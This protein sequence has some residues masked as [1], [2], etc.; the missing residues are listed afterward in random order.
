MEHKK[1]NS[2]SSFLKTGLK[3]G[4]LVGGALY[5]DPA[6][7]LATTG[8][9]PFGGIDPNQRLYPGNTKISKFVP[10]SYLPG[11][12]GEL[13]LNDLGGLAELN[14]SVIQKIAPKFQSLTYSDLEDI[15]AYVISVVG[16][17]T[18][19]FSGSLDDWKI[20]CCCCSCCCG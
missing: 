8:G 16:P 1:E 18:P 14:N 11:S 12:T 6:S 15:V 20:S 10:G 3:A 13:T 17:S 7:A 2:R 5:A 9:R 4:L 19:V